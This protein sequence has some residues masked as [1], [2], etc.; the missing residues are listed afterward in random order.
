MRRYR[1]RNRGG[2][3]FS[4]RGRPSFSR[5]WFGSQG[6][7]RRHHHVVPAAWP[8]LP[9]SQRDFP[10]LRISHIFSHIANRSPMDGRFAVDGGRQCIGGDRGI[11]TTACRKW[12]VP[13]RSA[14]PNP[15]G[16]PILSRLAGVINHA[17]SRTQLPVVLHPK[18]HFAYRLAAGGAAS[19]D[20]AARWSLA[21]GP[22]AATSGTM[23]RAASS[24]RPS[25]IQRE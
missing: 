2:C 19:N 15:T 13:N 8:P 5:R 16:C 6:K 1:G 21:D 20:Y 24:S 10:A 22:R 23:A 4:V 7:G 18:L 11:L 3:H 17:P 14:S 12:T 25:V 9:R